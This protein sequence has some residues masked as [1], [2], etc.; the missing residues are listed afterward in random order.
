MTPPTTAGPTLIGSVRR[1]MRLLEAV[2]EDPS[3]S[4]AKHLA[5]RTDIPIGTTYH[6]LRTLTHDGY[7][8]RVGGRY[9]I[10]AATARLGG[11]VPEQTSARDLQAWL[12]SLRDE[13]GAAIYYAWYEEGEVRM[14]AQSSGP[15]APACEEWA[16]F[17][18][19]AHAHAIGQCLL[20][21]LDPEARRDHLA[22]HPVEPLTPYTVPDA[23]A[24]LRKLAR[25]RRGQP[26]QEREE[27]APGTV[28]AAIPI[29]VGT[30]PAA[31]A[32]SLPMPRADLLDPLS[33]HLR[34]QAETA[35]T[36][37]AFTVR[38]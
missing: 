27:Y 38:V 10:S 13:T 18:R 15:R 14:V 24:L 2:A 34:R 16:D 25:L 36:S 31:L 26:V 11:A 1:A 12:D 32:L 19:T 30:V 20:S 6:L 4:T 8:H 7:L 22:R 33:H 21:Q 23:E 17:R 35:F 3:R 28:C 29:S 37:K 5:R 9:L